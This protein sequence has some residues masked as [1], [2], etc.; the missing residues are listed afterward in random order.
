MKEAQKIAVEIKSSLND[1][2]VYDLENAVGQYN[3]YREVLE[4]VFL[5]KTHFS[6]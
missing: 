3:I 5:N 6:S 2:A 1:S 4:R